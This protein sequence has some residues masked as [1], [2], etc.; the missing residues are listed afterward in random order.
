MLVRKIINILVFFSI[1]NNNNN[2]LASCE[3]L[4]VIFYAASRPLNTEP[5]SPSFEKLIEM[6][7]EE[8]PDTMKIGRVEIYDCKRLTI[9]FNIWFTPAIFIYRYKKEPIY[10]HNFLKVDMIMNFIRNEM[11][12]LYK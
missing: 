12:S 4:L 5:F 3:V 2:I 8:F 11:P 7:S 1:F 10:Y 9:R 6:V